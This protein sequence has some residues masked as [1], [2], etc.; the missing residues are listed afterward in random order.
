MT[1]RLRFCRKRAVL[2]R[3]NAARIEASMNNGN[4]CNDAL[5]STFLFHLLEVVRRETTLF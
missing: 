4:L 3:D 5:I 2:S 1:N